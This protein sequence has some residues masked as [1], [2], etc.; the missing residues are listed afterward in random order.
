M[1]TTKLT[2][3]VRNLGYGSTSQ[4]VQRRNG[5]RSWLEIESVD[6]PDVVGGLASIEAERARATRVNS[7]H[8]WREA[9]FLGGN[10]IV[11]RKDDVGEILA[12]LREHGEAIVT[13]PD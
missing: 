11:D 13:I 3:R 10:L 12:S 5:Q 7:G 9:L 4:P 2:T 6:S 8:D 1:K